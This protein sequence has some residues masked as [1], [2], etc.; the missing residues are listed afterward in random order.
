MK[1]LLRSVILLSALTLTGACGTSPAASKTGSPS[2]AAKLE[3]HSL[4]SVQKLHVLNNQFYLGSQPTE[5]DLRKS[6][7][8]GIKTIVNLRPKSELTFDEE[9]LVKSL[10]MNYVHIPMTA[11][12]IKNADID[13]FIESLSTKTN[14]PVF[15]HCASGNR[16][17]YMW[18]IYRLRHDGLSKNDAI[19]EGK[20]VG[21]KTESLIERVR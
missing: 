20:T 16:V 19:A 21:M 9:Q 10:G 13:K 4:G 1:T 11:D 3:P 5:D 6:K 18:S 12:S 7:E 17:G 8:K 2:A 15:V 14:E